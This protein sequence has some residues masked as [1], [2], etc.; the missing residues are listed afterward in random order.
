VFSILVFM[1]IATTATVP[2]LLTRGVAW[3]RDR[4]EL[5]KAGDRRSIMIVGAHPLARTAARLLGTG[6]PVILVD[7]NDSHVESARREG[8]TVYKGNAL[9]DLVLQEAGID[10]T[11]TFVAA[12]ANPEVNLLAVRSAQELGVNH[13][14]VTVPESAGDRFNPML[15][16]IGADSLVIPD[17]GMS[18]DDAIRRGLVEHRTVITEE[19]S[20]ETGDGDDEP[21]GRIVFPLVIGDET[22]RRLASTSSTARG[23]EPVSQLIRRIGAEGSHAPLADDQRDQDEAP[24]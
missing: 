11:M 20:E 21:E 2:V 19:N 23:G 24:A 6:S 10:Q 12:T 8:L 9:D 22:D 1:A 15:E 14:I 17:R 3:L 13:V 16:E 7:T 18:W 4:G 5:V